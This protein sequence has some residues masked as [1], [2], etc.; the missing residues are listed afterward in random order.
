MLVVAC[1]HH[2]SLTSLPPEARDVPDP[3]HPEPGAGPWSVDVGLC[4]R[5]P[6][7]LASMRLASR[8]SPRAVVGWLGA[9]AYLLYNS[10]IL[11]VATPY[12]RAAIGMVPVLLALRALTRVDAS[13]HDAT[14]LT[15]E[16]IS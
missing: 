9:A 6:L 12:N 2:P 11:L 1:M 10:T 16:G 8:G 15:T 4:P 14:V 13:A 5:V 7:L 3:D